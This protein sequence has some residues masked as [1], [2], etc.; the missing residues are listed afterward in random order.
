ME[1]IIYKV[2]LFIAFF[3]SLNILREA[4]TFYIC[5]SKMEKYDISN[6]RLFGLW[7]SISYLLTI[8]FTGIE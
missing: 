2:L 4:Y 6:Y 5:F 3:C 1:T 7:A 8:I